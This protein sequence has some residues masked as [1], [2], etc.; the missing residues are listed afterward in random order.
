MYKWFIFILMLSACSSTHSVIETDLAMSNKELVRNVFKA[1]ESGDL[2]TIN[3]AFD[4]NGQSI[5]G[6]SIRPRGGPHAS[7]AEAAPF[8]AALDNRSVE[9]E[10]LFAEGDMVGVQS[11]ICGTHARTLAGYKPSNQRICARYTNIYTVIDGRILKN[12]VGFDRDLR[13]LLE[14]NSK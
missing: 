5:I 11:K 4:P 14:K 6:S 13:P 8:P 1:L 7:F 2:D 12:A 9:I 3:Q 10:A